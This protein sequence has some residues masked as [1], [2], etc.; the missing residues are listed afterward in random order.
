MKTEFPNPN[1][2]VTGPSTSKK[3]KNALVQT[4]T[5]EGLERTVTRKKIA[6]RIKQLRIENNLAQADICRKFIIPNTSYSRWEDARTDV[7]SEVLLLLADYYNVSLDFIFGRTDNPR[8][9]HTPQESEDTMKEI[10]ETM[11]KLTAKIEELNAK[12]K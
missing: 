4:V 7:P 10:R 9:L 8:G 1:E 3:I 5:Q 12:V 6:T 2:A 11:D